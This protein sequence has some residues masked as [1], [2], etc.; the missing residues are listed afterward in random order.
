MHLIPTLTSDDADQAIAAAVDAARAAGIAATIAV[1]DAAGNLLSL[2]RM[3]GARGFSADLAARKARTSAVIGVPTA[4]LAQLYKDRP[5]PPEVMV[6]PGG[7]PVIS[8]G[9]AAGAIGVS[10]G[11][12]QVDEAIA[13]AAVGAIPPDLAAG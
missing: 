3:Q 2:K 13:K 4:V 10:G 7:V 9:K 6:V 1:V 5:A 12:A 11:D 8:G